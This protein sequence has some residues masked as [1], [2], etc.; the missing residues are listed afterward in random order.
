[1]FTF[2]LFFKASTLCAAL[3][4]FCG[5]LLTYTPSVRAADWY[6]RAVIG[7][8]SSQSADFFDDDCSSSDPPALFGCGTGVDGRPLGAYGDFGSFAV[9]DAAVG[10]RVL[11]W[12]RTDVSIAWRPHMVYSGEAN[13]RGVPGNQPVDSTASAFTAMLNVFIDLVY[14]AETP[15]S[16]FQPYI[17]GGVGI[18]YNRLDSMTYLF[19]EL[20]THKISVTPS[21]SSVHPAYTLALGTGIVISERISLDIAYRW[22]HLGRV[23]TDAG[24]MYMNHMPQGIDIAGTSAPLRTHGLH[25]GLRYNF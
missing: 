7:Y 10:R 16:R 12:L 20:T 1:M 19:P 25:V 13:F 22:S 24:R 17:G 8:E 3:S 5:V 9:L 11:P 23:E 2:R 4:V 18:S 21:G 6:A 14:K 15:L